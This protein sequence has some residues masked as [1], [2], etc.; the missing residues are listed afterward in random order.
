MFAWYNFVETP[1]KFTV[2]KLSIRKHY[3]I[4]SDEDP[5]QLTDGK[6]CDDKL[7]FPLD[8]ELPIDSIISFSVKL[9]MQLKNFR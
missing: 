4:S 1:R 3:I 5:M 9:T 8:H 6:H 7:K 2:A